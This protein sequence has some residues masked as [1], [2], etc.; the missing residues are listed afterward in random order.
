[1]KYALPLVAAA[2]LAL[3]GACSKEPAEPEAQ[4]TDATA[5]E[6]A[7]AGAETGTAAPG[8]P[9][10]LAGDEIPEAMRGRWGLVPADCTSTKGDAK[11]LM[12]VEADSLKFYESVATLGMVE[13]VEPDAI[14]AAYEF[15]GEGQT[16]ILDVSLE[17]SDDGQTLV[18]HDKGPDAMPDP[19]TYTRCAA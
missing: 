14:S 10:A 11:G 16:W 2:T 1:M 13:N 9:P 6:S 18:R 5:M 8:E 15:S 4:G 19:L 7:S 12:T 3:L 17:M